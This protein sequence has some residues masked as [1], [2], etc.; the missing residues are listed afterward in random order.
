[1][2]NWAFIYS[3]TQYL[4]IKKH[5]YSQTLK[6][7]FMF[8]FWLLENGDVY[9]WTYVKGEVEACIILN[10]LFLQT[11]TGTCIYLMERGWLL[12]YFCNFVVCAVFKW[13]RHRDGYLSSISLH[14]SW[15]WVNTRTVFLK[16]VLILW[17]RTVHLVTKAFT[18]EF[19]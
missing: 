3:S 13:E 8:W 1:M 11:V 15:F 16:K 2:A 6:L 18:E 19:E 5:I 17:W 7:D 10:H 4:H 12:L 9:S 14:K